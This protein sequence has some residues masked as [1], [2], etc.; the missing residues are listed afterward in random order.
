MVVLWGPFTIVLSYKKKSIKS[1]TRVKKRKIA[2]F[3]LMLILKIIQSIY[4][5]HRHVIK[6]TPDRTTTTTTH[7]N[8]SVRRQLGLGFPDA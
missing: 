2:W 5:I 1:C 6:A 8:Y 3:A 4:I 7:D